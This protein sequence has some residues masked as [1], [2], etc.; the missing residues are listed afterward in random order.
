MVS[1]CG[2]VAIPDFIF[3]TFLLGNAMKALTTLEVGLTFLDAKL[4]RDYGN[5]GGSA[6]LQICYCSSKISTHCFLIYF[7]DLSHHI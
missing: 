6:A 2:V 1:E 5:V 4:P 7:L 3:E